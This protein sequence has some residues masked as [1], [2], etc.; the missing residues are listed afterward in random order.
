MLAGKMVFLKGHVT[1]KKHF[2]E[3]IVQ[4]LPFLQKAVPASN[5]RIV[6]HWQ[7]QFCEL[8]MHDPCDRQM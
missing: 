2:R 5:R 8:I 3:L 4:L 1:S 7:G 6:L